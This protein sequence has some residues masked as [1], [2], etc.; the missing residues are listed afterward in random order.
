MGKR[1]PG[2]FAGRIKECKADL[3]RFRIGRDVGAKGKYKEAKEKLENIFDQREIFWRQRSKQLWLQAGDK[4]LKYFHKTASGRQRNN[5]IQKLQDAD[6][7]W[8]DWGHGL[9]GLI[10]NYFNNL[11]AASKAEWQEVVNCVPGT[12]TEVQ[13]EELLRPVVEDEVKTALFQMNP[14][15]ASG[16]DGM[17]STF[18]QKHWRIEVRMW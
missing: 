15:K 18:F 11:F 2:N 1:N 5:H 13:N 8:L 10:T 16:P 17:T 9:P 14:D 3:K 12:I 4:N 7:N 6:G